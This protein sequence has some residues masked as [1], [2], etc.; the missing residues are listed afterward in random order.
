MAAAIVQIEAH[1]HEVSLSRGGTAFQEIQCIAQYGPS[2]PEEIRILAKLAIFD[3]DAL[4]ELSKLLVEIDPIY[5]ATMG[6]TQAVDLISGGV[7]V[8]AL[9]EKAE[10]IVNH[11]IAE[12]R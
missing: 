9:P 6:T 5:A 12:D 10:A 4:T 2:V 1:P 8:N 7:K 11:R 3:D